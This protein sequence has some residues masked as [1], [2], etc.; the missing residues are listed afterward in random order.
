MENNIKIKSNETRVV[1][2]GKESHT[3]QVWST[4]KISILHNG[5]KIEKEWLVIDLRDDVVGYLD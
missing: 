4:E 3:S 1:F 5:R 2:A